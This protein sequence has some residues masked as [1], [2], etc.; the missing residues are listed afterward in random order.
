M[1]AA[2]VRYEV[3]VVPTMMTSDVISQRIDEFAQQLYE[4]MGGTFGS[5][6]RWPLIAPVIRSLFFADLINKTNNFGSVTWLGQPIWQNVLDLWTIQETIAEVRPQLLV[7][8]GTY[9]GGSS[10]FYANLFDLM[11][12]GEVVTIDV[13]KRHELSH[14]RVTYLI[15]D[16]TSDEVLAKVR[17]KSARCSGPVM[18]ILDSD[19][20]QAHVRREIERYAP[21]V[22]PGSYCLVQDGVIDT[23]SV[24]R[25]YR[26]G[27]L[28]AIEEFLRSTQEFE[29]D[30]ARS[31]R[32][33]VTHHPKGWLRRKCVSNRDPRA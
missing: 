21:L 9:R 7:E 10:L 20:S 27:P 33:L 28:P 25:S 5:G 12:Q 8:C 17:E 16:S 31:E 23:L 14:P 26:P 18:V 13:E 24:F 1:T 19:H 3:K 29:L 4:E 2:C 32:Y 11:G 22:T 6:E 15:G 30:A